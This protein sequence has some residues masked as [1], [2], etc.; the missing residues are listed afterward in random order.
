MR[1]LE[2][3]VSGFGVYQTA[4]DAITQ[5]IQSVVQAEFLHEARAMAM[6]RVRTQKQSTGDIVIAQSIRYKAQDFP[7][8]RS[9]C[10][11]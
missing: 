9:Q 10:R 2:S 8:A 7:F 6:H 1:A 4:L 3:C 5:N 11:I